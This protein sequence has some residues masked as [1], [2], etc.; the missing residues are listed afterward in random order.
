[1]TQTPLVLYRK[2]HKPYHPIYL[3]NTT[4]ASWWRIIIFSCKP[5][6]IISPIIGN[7]ILTINRLAFKDLNKNGKLDIYEDWRLPVEERARDLTAKMSV[8]QIAGLMLYSS[9]QAIPS[10]GGGFM[11][12]GTYGA[13]IPRQYYQNTLISYYYGLVLAIISVGIN[14]Y[15]SHL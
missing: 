10:A 1:M 5:I 2:S 7:K 11:P 3:L 8:D 6:R 4:T 14:Y 13:F 15:L 12:G 9:H